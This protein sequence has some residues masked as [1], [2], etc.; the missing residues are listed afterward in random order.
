MDQLG[1]WKRYSQMNHQPNAYRSAKTG[2]KQTGKRYRLVDKEGRLLDTLYFDHI[3]PILCQ[4]PLQLL[5]QNF[6]CI[7]SPKKV[8]NT[9][10]FKT[11]SN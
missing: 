7:L 6:P 3:D 2:S 11:K 4:N 10:T 5:N 9:L 1:H 8:E